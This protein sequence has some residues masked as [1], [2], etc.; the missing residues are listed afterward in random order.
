MSPSPFLLSAANSL[1]VV[2]DIQTKLTAILPEAEAR[3]MGAQTQ[4]LLSAA[5]LLEIPVLVTEQ[6]PEG[7]GATDS[8]IGDNL[9]YA[10]Q[11][12][13]KTGFSVRAAD[14]FAAALRQ[15]GRK[16]LVLAGLEAHV[17]V[18]QSALDCQHAG[19]QVHVVADAVCSRALGNKRH[20]LQRMRQQGIT[21]STTESVLFEWLADAKH[22][23]FKSIA[24]L[25]R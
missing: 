14:G 24:A 2:I 19:Y 1:L 15:T 22:P 18:L 11:M 13:S 21:V 25:I 7:L 12:F 23:E 17:C 10:A 4:K 16:Q 5:K 9:P 3:H 20:A 8:A 6:Y